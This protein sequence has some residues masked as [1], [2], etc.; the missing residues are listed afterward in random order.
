MIFLNLLQRFFLEWAKY[1][2]FTTIFSIKI[3]G[4][5][6]LKI[7]CKLFLALQ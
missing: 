1:N 7:F 2:S 6:Y 3:I 4:I 5:G